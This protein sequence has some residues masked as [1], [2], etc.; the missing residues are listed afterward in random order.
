MLIAN[1]LGRHRS[2]PRMQGLRQKGLRSHSQVRLPA[3][4]QPQPYKQSN[5]QTIDGERTRR[6]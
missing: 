3:A 1:G 2:Q 5:L 4:V 6:L